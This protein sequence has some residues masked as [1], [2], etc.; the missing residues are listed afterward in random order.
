M[1]KKICITISMMIFFAFSGCG[2]SNEEADN[3]NVEISSEKPESIVPEYESLPE[4][5]IEEEIEEKMEESFFVPD[6][7]EDE[8]NTLGNSYANLS[9]ACVYLTYGEKTDRLTG[10][11]TGQGDW[12]YWYEN[13]AI[14]KRNVQGD[15]F[16]LAYVEKA[17]SLN[18]VGEWIYY[19][20]DDRIERIRTDG[21]MQEIVLENV[22]GSF[23][24]NE[25]ILY[26]VTNKAVSATNYEYYIQE[27]D[28]E[29][30][31]VIQSYTAEYVA[32]NNEACPVLIGIYQNKIYYYYLKGIKL[33]DEYFTVGYFIYEIS[34]DGTQKYN[35]YEGE[36]HDIFVVYMLEEDLIW[37]KYG[38]GNPIISVWDIQS[39]IENQQIN[40]DIVRNGYNKGIIGG[41]TFRKLYYVQE[42]NVQALEIDDWWT[43][44]ETI[45]EEACDIC[46]VYVVGEYIY[47]TIDDYEDAAVYRVKID[48]TDWSQL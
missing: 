8:I 26:Y 41:P 30:K 40:N 48:G 19:L 43:N 15:T 33:W 13:G 20:I 14:K 23:F 9:L 46:E 42:M 35:M 3:T 6:C 2:A 10:R 38:D 11:V 44:G 45:I 27:Y 1:L 32:E 12:I 34:E 17:S 31:C 16:D 28:I 7:S 36:L 39:G 47:Y 22:C 18:V 29:E 21:K 25:N 5:V 37:A 24:V 4:N